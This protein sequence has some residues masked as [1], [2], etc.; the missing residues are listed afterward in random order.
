MRKGNDG[1]ARKLTCTPKRYYG[2]RH[3]AANPTDR[4]TAEQLAVVNQ[5]VI[6]EKLLRTG[7]DCE[8]RGACHR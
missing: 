3:R 4:G 1:I 5:V 2:A 6:A 7:V 8:R